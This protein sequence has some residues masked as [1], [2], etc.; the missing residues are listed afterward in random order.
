MPFTPSSLSQELNRFPFEVVKKWLPSNARSK[1]PGS[2]DCLDL[3]ISTD[4][5]A[6]DLRM[7]CA[8]G[9]AAVQAV[10]Q[11]L[12]QTVKVRDYLGRG[13]IQ[14]AVSQGR[15]PKRLKEKRSSCSDAHFLNLYVC[16]RTSGAYRKRPRLVLPRSCQLGIRGRYSSACHDAAR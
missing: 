7:R 8:G 6:R 1:N 12:S 11:D 13:A 9:P 10:M 4:R 16:L 14:S 5:G 3:Q 15:S 2:P